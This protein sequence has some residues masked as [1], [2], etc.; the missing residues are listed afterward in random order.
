MSY[1]T[2]SSGG[3]LSELQAQK[4]LMVA[5]ATGGPRIDD[6]NAEY[7][8]RRKRIHDELARLGI[9][10]ANPYPDL[11]SWYGKWSGGDLP[12]YQSRRQYLSELLDP[13][14]G[15]VQQGAGQHARV[16]EEPS[17]WA[18]VDR[19][20]DGAREQLA[21]AQSEED[22]QAVGFRCREVLIS[23]GQEVF[24]STRHSTLDGVSPSDTDAKRMLEAYVRSELSGNT[25]EEARKHARAALDFANALQ[26]KR[27]ATFRDAALCAEAT[28]SI[29]NLIAILSG[30]R[31]P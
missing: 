2:S 4:N 12:S 14:T 17:G 21:K 10:D 9:T 1:Q 3:I 25:N 19:Q 15:A 7:M 8:E 13:M 16:F 22:F 28:A 30:R 6:V 18:K 20:L 23:L 11:W 29:V 26:H 31:D 5:V 27:T 24:D